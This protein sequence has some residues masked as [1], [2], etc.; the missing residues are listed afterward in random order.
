MASYYDGMVH[1]KES[2]IMQTTATELR[3]S[4][5]FI[6]MIGAIMNSEHPW[7]VF[8]S[9]DKWNSNQ[10]KIIGLCDCHVYYKIVN[11]TFLKSA[12]AF[13]RAEGVEKRKHKFTLF[14]DCEIFAGLM[15]PERLTYKVVFDKFQRAK[16]AI[17][18]A[19]KLESLLE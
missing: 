3:F 1:K 12:I 8:A 18:E 9:T 5:H 11:I 19:Q 14:I 7:L 10:K 4:E 15:D 2:T 13:M 16:A 6:E 17:K